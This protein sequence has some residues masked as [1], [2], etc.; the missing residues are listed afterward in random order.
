MAIEITYALISVIAV[1]AV[2]LIGVITVS[3]S[4]KHLHSIVLLLVA[5]AVGAFLGD[6]FIHLIPEAFEES[7]NT[8]LTS[9]LIVGG[10]LFFF[11]LEKGLHWHHH[12]HI[13]DPCL[14]DDCEPHTTKP[15]GQIVLISDSIHNLIDGIIIGISYFISVEVGIATTIAVLLHEVP[16]EMGDFGILLHAGYTKRKALLYNL[17]SALFA[18][19]GV[20]IVIV[21]QD[22]AEQIAGFVVP[23]IAGIFI[24]IASADLVPELHKEK[25][26]LRTVFEVG[27]VIVGVFLM[28]LLL[29]LE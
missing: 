12:A 20:L 7:T 6:A 23:I 8:T 14:D 13:N 1:S 28:Y 19:V 3:F 25:R 16:Q 26:G 10:M 21:A 24:Y 29:F 2:S 11:V 27:A 18:V 15:L 4:Q 9:L 17:L 5:L 22:F